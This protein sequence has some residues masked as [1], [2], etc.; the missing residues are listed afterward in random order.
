[1]N[2]FLV[3]SDFIYD[4]NVLELVQY[5]DNYFRLVLMNKRRKKGYELVD[6]IFNKKQNEFYS[7][8]IDRISL[9]RT[10]R[11]I[12]EI[13]LCN[14]FTYFATVTVNSDKTIS[15]HG[16]TTSQPTLIAI[17]KAMTLKAHKKY[18]LTGAYSGSIQLSLRD[19][20]M[21]R[22][23]AEDN[24]NGVKYTPN[25]DIEAIVFIR[26]GIIAL[27]S[28]VTLYPMLRYADITDD[29]YESYKESVDERLI[30]NKSDI[31]INRST[32]GYQRKNLFDWKNAVAVRSGGVTFNKTD[33]DISVTSSGA[34]ASV[35]YKLP[36]LE[37][38][39]KYTFSAT[40]SNLS[41]VAS[42]VKMRLS[43]GSGGG[44]QITDMDLTENGEY[45]ANFTPTK[46]TVYVL[47]YPNFSETTYTNG[48]TASDIMLRYADI[49]DSTYEPYRPSLQ[50]QI[51][52]LSDTSNSGKLLYS[53]SEVV[54]SP[55]TV[56]ITGLFTA[57]T[58]VVCNVVTSDGKHSL[59]LPLQY[60]KSLGASSY[61]EAESILFHY[62]DDNKIKISTGMG[63][64]N[65]TI[66]IVRIINLL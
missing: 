11:N 61:Y 48:F 65:P 45:K 55:L 29:T 53:M 27:D 50:E 22:V 31:A 12:R 56:N 26:I 62:I 5:N 59:I 15:V 66:N 17:T 19:T 9:S 21:S 1:M 57:Y 34:W 10:K 44:N 49:T 41:K 13:C 42:T 64:S 36:D 16:T 54:S 2:K 47:F 52:Q 46:S 28:P 33:N 32:L 63:Q 24:G 30:K 25:K 39:V 37:I 60:I 4:N 6:K 23:L 40:V 51:N 8:E 18:C 20:S 14:D 3:P 7:Q 38:G 58:V 43:Y 35:A